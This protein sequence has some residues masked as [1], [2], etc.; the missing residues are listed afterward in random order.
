LNLSRRRQSRLTKPVELLPFQ[1]K[2]EDAQKDEIFKLVQRVSSCRGAPT[3]V[4]QENGSG[5]AI[6]ISSEARTPRS[7]PQYGPNISA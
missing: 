5:G 3:T 4:R 1:L 2:M 6:G 7:P